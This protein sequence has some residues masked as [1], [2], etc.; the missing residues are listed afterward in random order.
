[1]LYTWVNIQVLYK[2]N[3]VHA[4]VLKKHKKVIKQQ[5][6]KLLSVNEILDLT[7]MMVFKRP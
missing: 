5:F 1:M 6:Y 4:F 7:L 2:K 3:I